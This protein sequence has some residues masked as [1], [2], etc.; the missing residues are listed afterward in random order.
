[1]GT[2]IYGDDKKKRPS[3]KPSRAKVPNEKKF[4]VARDEDT[5]TDTHRQTDRVHHPKGQTPPKW[6]LNMTSGISCHRSPSSQRPSSQLRTCNCCWEW[7]LADGKTL[8][9]S[10]G[11]EDRWV[12]SVVDGLLFPRYIRGLLHLGGYVLQYSLGCQLFAGDQPEG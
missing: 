7:T 11:A 12:F 9:D 10:T 1:M 8:N 4:S 6:T 5:D 2:G 3:F